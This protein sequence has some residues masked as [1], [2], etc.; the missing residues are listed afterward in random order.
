MKQNIELHIEELVLHGFSHS[1]RYR[2]GAAVEL[3]L[4]R[5]FTVQCTPSLLLKGGGYTH[6]DCGAFEIEPGSKPETIG[7]QVARALYGGLSL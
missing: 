4:S 3:E 7:A 5:L 2:I 1:D 6:L